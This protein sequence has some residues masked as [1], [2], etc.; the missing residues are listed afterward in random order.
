MRH[1]EIVIIHHPEQT[2][3]T[4]YYKQRTIQYTKQPI[5]QQE[6]RKQLWDKNVQRMSPHIKIHQIAFL[7]VCVCVFTLQKLVFVVLCAQ[8]MHFMLVQKEKHIQ[9]I[10]KIS[11]QMSVTLSHKYQTSILFFIYS[12]LKFNFHPLDWNDS[13]RQL[14]QKIETNL[15]FKW[16]GLNTFKIIQY[17]I[18]FT[19]Y[20]TINVTQL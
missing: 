15:F 9:Q 12:S 4:V 19:L 1:L 6:Q 7:C 8:K 18:N 20:C 10:E 3:I 5:K 13:K 2:I 16:I 17:R 11:V 14:E